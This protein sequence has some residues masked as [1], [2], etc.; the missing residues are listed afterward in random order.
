[1]IDQK[2]TLPLH[3]EIAGGAVAEQH[4]IVR[5]LQQC[6]AVVAQSSCEVFKCK[7]IIPCIHKLVSYVRLQ[8][9]HHQCLQQQ[10]LGDTR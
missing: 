4:C 1:M 10:K 6:A 5:L 9:R 3:G 7:G 2:M 8:M